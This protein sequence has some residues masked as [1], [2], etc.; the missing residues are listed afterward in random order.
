[1]LAMKKAFFTDVLSFSDTLELE[2]AA[3]N[4]MVLWY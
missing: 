1:M 3:C 4:I 2:F